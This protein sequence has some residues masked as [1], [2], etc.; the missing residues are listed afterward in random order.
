MKLYLYIFL[1]VTFGLCS[2]EESSKQEEEDST[3]VDVEL[4]DQETFVKVFAEAQ[5][6]ES[7]TTVLRIYQPYYKDSADNYYKALFDKYGVSSEQFY[8]SMQA[9]S[10]DPNLMN[11]LVNEAVILLKTMDQEL[12]DVKIPNHSLN[13]ISRQQ[14]GDIIF[15][16]PI[17]NLML[18]AEPILAGFLRD[19]LFTYLDSF[20]NIVSEKGYNMES[21]RFTFI[22]NTNNKMMFNQLKTYLQNKQ[23]KSEGVD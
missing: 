10:K 17:N 21:V 16:T 12:G 23:D 2:C 5:I 8:Y 13:S 3:P 4:I 14:L 19:S 11:Q 15:E 6:I 18:E 1:W 7:H 20:P 9:Y 22:L